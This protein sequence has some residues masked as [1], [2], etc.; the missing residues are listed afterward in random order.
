[1]LNGPESLAVELGYD[2][3]HW[4]EAAIP[5]A[6]SKPRTLAFRT[7]AAHSLEAVR[8]AHRAGATAV[9]FGPVFAPGWKAAE[10][11]GLAALRRCTDASPLPVFA[12]GG[13]GPGQVPDCLA[14]GAH[15]VAVLS[16]IAGAADPV[17]AALDC[18][19]AVL[20]Q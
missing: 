3:V 2:G 18:L 13:I 17:A 16:G 8:R 1:M 20:H 4:P 10:P 6:P 15:G 9:V 5:D 14:A 11:V 12:L 7:A 19:T